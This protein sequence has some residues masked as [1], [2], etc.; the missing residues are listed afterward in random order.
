M[1]NPFAKINA[2][3]AAIKMQEFREN[4]VLIK[5]RGRPRRPNMRKYLIKMDVVLQ[6]QVTKKAEYLGYS[7]SFFIPEAVS[8]YHE[9]DSLPVADLLF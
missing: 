2:S 4:K 6:S 9:S 8:N 1:K 7:N 5:G 3:D